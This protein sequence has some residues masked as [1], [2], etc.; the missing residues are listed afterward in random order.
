M[1]IKLIKKKSVCMYLIILIIINVLILFIF[2]FLILLVLFFIIKIYILLHLF[3][4]L[5]LTFRTL[6]LNF[7]FM[8][9]WNSSILGS[10]CFICLVM[11]PFLQSARPIHSLSGNILGNAIMFQQ[12]YL[13]G[14]LWSVCWWGS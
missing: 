8:L 12:R 10:A 1:Y 3:H 5:L 13:K 9:W 14:L 2:H 6:L 7:L 11:R 4:F